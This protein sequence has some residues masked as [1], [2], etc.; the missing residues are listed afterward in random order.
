M[1]DDDGIISTLSNL[2]RDTD[3]LVSVNAVMALNEIL[4][5]EGGIPLSPKLVKYLYG[6]LKDYN[7]WEQC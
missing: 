5:S 1:L 4:V 3:S 7:S 2:I 6:R